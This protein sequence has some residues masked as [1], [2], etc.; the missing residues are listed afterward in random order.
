MPIPNIHNT[1]VV[2][3]S[4]DLFTFPVMPS[5]HSG[6]VIGDRLMH[7]IPIQRYVCT[8]CG[9]IEEWVNSPRNLL[10]LKEEHRKQHACPQPRDGVSSF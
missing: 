5:E 6:L 1:C 2:C 10:L 4:L 9:H 8:D 7:M 3:G